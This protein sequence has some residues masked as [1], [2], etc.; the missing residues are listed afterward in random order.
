M[1]DFKA[2]CTKIQRSP[3]PLAGFKGPT[4]KEGRG[5]GKEGNGRRRGMN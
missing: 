3:R 5:T 2:K 1:S 4:S